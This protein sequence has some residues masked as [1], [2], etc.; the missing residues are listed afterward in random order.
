MANEQNLK[1]FGK[2]KPAPTSE[3]AKK[4]GSKGGKASAEKRAQVKTSREIVEMLDSLAVSPSNSEVMET[5]GIPEDMR[6]RQ[7]LRLLQL[8][9]KAEQ[10]DAQAN[11]LL[12]EIRGEAAASTVN[13]EVNPEVREAYERAAAAIKGTTNK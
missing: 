4:A 6:T 3:E 11:K 5:L 2:E 12:L 13:L 10:G 9:K 8:Q 1:R 7:T